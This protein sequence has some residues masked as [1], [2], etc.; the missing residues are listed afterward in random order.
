LPRPLAPVISITSSLRRVIETADALQSD[1]DDWSLAALLEYCGFTEVVSSPPPSILGVVVSEAGQSVLSIAGRV[2]GSPVE[3]LVRAR[4][5]AGAI[6]ALGSPLS[7]SV[8]VAWRCDLTEA[9]AELAR[10]RAGC[11]L[12]VSAQ[13]AADCHAGARTVAAI[14]R[15]RSVP[16]SFVRA[17][18]IHEMLLGRIP[19]D[20]TAAPLLA[21]LAVMCRH[22]ARWI[23]GELERLNQ[24]P[25]RET[26]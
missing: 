11:F 2:L 24:P 22:G 20:E 4:L 23:D 15:Q 21:R 16:P 10:W 19:T 8:D 5:M 1:D 9:P 12:A 7:P 26:G 14:A 6:A 13:D 3:T 25:C 17:R 18:V